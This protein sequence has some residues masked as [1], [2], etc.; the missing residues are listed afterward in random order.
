[1]EKA[2]PDFLPIITGFP[3]SKS[4]EYP[5]IEHRPL[6]GPSVVNGKNSKSDLQPKK[7][8]PNAPFLVSI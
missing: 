1:M 7:N 5:S 4:M 8:Y 3:P 2:S 6:V